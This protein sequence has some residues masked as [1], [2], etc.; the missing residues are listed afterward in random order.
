MSSRHRW[1]FRHMVGWR[2]FR[3][4]LHDRQGNEIK[5]FPAS[6]K[7]PQ[8]DGGV[9]GNNSFGRPILHIV[10]EI[11]DGRIQNARNIKQSAGPDPIGASFILLHLLKGEPKSFA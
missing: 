4:L 9:I 5:T 2:P 3:N 7:R 11:G 1:L 8:S 10:K 6:R